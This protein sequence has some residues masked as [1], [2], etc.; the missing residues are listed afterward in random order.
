MIINNTIVVQLY[1]YNFLYMCI[2]K[3]IILQRRDQSAK[4]YVAKIS[5]WYL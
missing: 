3:T 1:N 4:I 2:N 5:F